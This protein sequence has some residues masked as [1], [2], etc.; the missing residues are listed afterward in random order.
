M[1][2]LNIVL[3]GFMGTGKTTVGRIVAE[4]LNM[5]FI[6]TDEEIIRTAGLSITEIFEGFGE[7][8]FRNLEEEVVERVT[9]EKG[10]VIASGGGVILRERNINNLKKNGVIF[11]LTAD[12]N[13]I[14]KRLCGSIDRP[15]VK[16]NIEDFFRLLEERKERYFE[17]ADYVIDTNKITSESVARE[18]ID[19]YK[20]LTT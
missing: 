17:T 10:L 14:L 16:K 4:E 18:I 7:K 19:I 3:T 20:K 13:E 2:N 12:R 5:K 8:G 1:F 9:S 11:L 6:D 15:L